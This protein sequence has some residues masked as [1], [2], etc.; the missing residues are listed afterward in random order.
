MIKI[1]RLVKKGLY[2]LGYGIFL[3]LSVWVLLELAF[4]YQWIDFYAT[5]LRGLNPANA[6]AP[7]NDQKTILVLG[8]SFS[9]QPK[10]Y[11]DVLRDS[12][13]QAAL[14]NAAV[15]GT[16]IREARVMAAGRIKSFP[17]DV[18]LYQVYVGNDLWDIRKT[19]DNPHIS[20]GRNLYWHLSDYSLVLRFLNYKSGQFKSRA[21]VATETLELK[22]DIPF[23]TTLYSKREQLILRAEPDLLRNSIRAEARR[24]A[25]LR[26]WFE[27]MDGL[28]TL[29]PARTQKVI[30]LV[31]PHCAQV[32]EYYAGNIQAIGGML[33]G[34]EIQQPNYPFLQ[35]L[36]QH[37][38]R[39]PR[40]RVFSP[41]PLFQQRDST[42]HRLYY[43]NDPHLSPE[44]H[45]LLGLA[46][47][48][49][50]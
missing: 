41:L 34:P 49:L 30:I 20:S 15:P 36:E 32:H 10:S 37:F 9:A 14:V 22:Q 25:D 13:P 47:R 27:K 33:S 7:Q 48:P 4:R 18:L 23:S 16:G 6:L 29:L 5:E 24:G 28:L 42:G 17:P 46:I 40:V 35:A 2:A 44:G 11:V 45:R 3:L 26:V 12:L 38:A 1:R 50:L 19:C 21:G 8:D 39:D 31:V 43:E